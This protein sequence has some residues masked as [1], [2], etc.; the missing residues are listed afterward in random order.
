MGETRIGDMRANLGRWGK[1]RAICLAFR[2]RSRELAAS[3]QTASDGRFSRAI[4][5]T[6]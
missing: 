6:S 4:D 5:S 3:S 2:Y 1:K